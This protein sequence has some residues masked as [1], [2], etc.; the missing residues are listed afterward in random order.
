MSAGESLHVSDFSYEATSSGYM[1]KYKGHNIGGAGIIG[2]YKSRRAWAQ[3]KEYDSN[4]R[5]AINALCAGRGE[6]RYL[7]AIDQIRKAAVCA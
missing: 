2:K 7:K 4:A 6:E 5:D 3:A 1:I